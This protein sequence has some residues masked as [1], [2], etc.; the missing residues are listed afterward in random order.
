MLTDEDCMS[1]IKEIDESDRINLTDW[2][3][4]FVESNLDEEY[5]SDKQKEVIENLEEKYL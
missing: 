3:E 1:I 2:E 5:F 4:K